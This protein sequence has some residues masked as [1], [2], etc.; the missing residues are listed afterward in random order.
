MPLVFFMA[1]VAPRLPDG[2]RVGLVGLDDLL[3]SVFKEGKP[4][5]DSTAMQLID[6]LRAEIYIP[7]SAAVSRSFIRRLFSMSTS[8]T[9]RARNGKQIHVYMQTCPPH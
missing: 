1:A 3:E 4:P 6:R 2:D 9:M 8:V 7:S 5:E